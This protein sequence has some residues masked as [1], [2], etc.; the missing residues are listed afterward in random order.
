MT[1]PQEQVGIDMFLNKSNIDALDRIIKIEDDRLLQTN[2][3]NSIINTMKYILLTI[4]IVYILIS[5]FIY[6][7]KN[8]I[9][10]IVYI[11]FGLFICLFNYLFKFN[12]WYL[13]SIII[14]PIMML[15]FKRKNVK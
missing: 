8:K 14:L 1:L 2:I 4:G 15:I 12:Y 3:N 6:N 9:L 11:A 10:F 5:Y 7:N 13:Y